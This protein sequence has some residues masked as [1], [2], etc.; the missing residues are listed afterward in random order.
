MSYNELASFCQQ[1]LEKYDM[2]RKEN[3]KMKNK[4]DCMLNENSLKRKIISK[5][6]ENVPKKKK[7]VDHAFHATIIDKNEVKFLKNK[8]NCLSSTLSKCAFN[9]TR[10]ESL[11]SKKQTPHVHAHHPHAYSVFARH[12]HTH[13]HMHAKVYKYCD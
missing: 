9:H 3:K 10:L 4:F 5:E 12:D 6:K 8:I 13:T 1:L 11:F 2:L 7:I